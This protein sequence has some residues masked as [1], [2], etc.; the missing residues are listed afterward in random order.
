MDS[1]R[2]PNG[3]IYIQKVVGK[4]LVL[5]PTKEV[6]TKEVLLSQLTNYSIIQKCVVKD[7]DKIISSATKYRPL[8]NDIWESMPTKKMMET[9]TYNIGAKH[10]D[11]YNRFKWCDSLGMCIQ[12]KDDNGTLEEILHMVEVNQYSIYI[13]IQLEPGKIV[14]FRK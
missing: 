4:D 8:L 3:A 2:I 5:T 10:N 9:T 7:G 1:I 13:R 12:S 14:I 11:G 6:I